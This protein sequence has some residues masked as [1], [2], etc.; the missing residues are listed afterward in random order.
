MIAGAQI[1]MK[2]A[3]THSDWT[4]TELLDSIPYLRFS[5]IIVQTRLCQVIMKLISDCFH[6]PSPHFRPLP[7]LLRAVLWEWALH[8]HQVWRSWLQL[9]EER[10]HVKEDPAEHHNNGARKRRLHSYAKAAKE[11]KQLRKRVLCLV[12][13]SDVKIA[14]II[15][16]GRSLA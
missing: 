8:A 3:R 7:C 10:E 9:L 1:D 12:L 2:I 13:C 16:I 14:G 5:A 15:A 4:I 6:C 11:S